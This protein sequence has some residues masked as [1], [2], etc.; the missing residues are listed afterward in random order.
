MPEND[1]NDTDEAVQIELPPQKTVVKIED[2]TKVEGQ[3]PKKPD[4]VLTEEKPREAVK[5]VTANVAEEKKRP[6]NLGDTNAQAQNLATDTISKETPEQAVPTTF[7]KAEEEKQGHLPASS[8]TP[9]T[10]DVSENL[11]VAKSE[12]ATPSR[13][14]E[15]KTPTREL[16]SDLPSAVDTT[17]VGAEKQVA[18]DK[19]DPK[20]RRG[21]TPRPKGDLKESKPAALVPEDRPKFDPR[22]K[23]VSTGKNIAGWI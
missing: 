18:S 21:S 22:G 16:K 2:E 3:P 20:V 15:R 9:K 17:R 10:V 5:E 6:N 11:D 7:V 4:R 8:L 1:D 14:E 13:E 23:S 19:P 12:P